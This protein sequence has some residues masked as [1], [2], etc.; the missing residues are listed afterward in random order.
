MPVRFGLGF[1]LASKE[2]PLPFPNAFH[3]GGNGGSSL[4]ME[5]DAR[6]CWSY[7]PNRLDP[8]DVIDTRG[9]R[10]IAAACVGVASSGT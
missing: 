3:W 5:P 10:L 7:V 6:A 9:T 1:G 4:V 8:A 2:F